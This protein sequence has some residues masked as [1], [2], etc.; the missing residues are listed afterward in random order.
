MPE[1]SDKAPKKL[2]ELTDAELLKQANEIENSVVQ[3]EINNARKAGFDLGQAR[4]LRQL[5]EERKTP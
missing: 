2:L 3:F 4:V 1:T 5:A